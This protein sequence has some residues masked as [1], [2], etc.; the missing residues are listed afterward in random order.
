M[1]SYLSYN[2]TSHRAYRARSR[3]WFLDPG[4]EVVSWQM[5]D[6]EVRV[7]LYQIIRTKS[8]LRHQRCRCIWDRE[9]GNPMV[10]W[11]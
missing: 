11:P 2:D 7:E 1:V 6:E 8:Q 10:F 3:V 5:R 4:S 9:T